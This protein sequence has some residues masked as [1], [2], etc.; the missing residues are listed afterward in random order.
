MNQKFGDM[1]VKVLIVY[2]IWTCIA[3]IFNLGW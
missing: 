1:F 2:A 3:F